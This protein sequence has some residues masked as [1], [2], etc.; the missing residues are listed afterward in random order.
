LDHTCFK[1]YQI[2]KQGLLCA[3]EVKGSLLKQVYPAACSGEI[4]ELALNQLAWWVA[5]V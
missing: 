5:A 1:R 2:K 3:E 4:P